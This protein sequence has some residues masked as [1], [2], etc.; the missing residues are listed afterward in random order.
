MAK[1]VPAFADD[2]GAIHLTAEKAVLA[3]L[4]AILGRIGAEAGLTNGLAQTILD[5][6]SDIERIFAQAD[7]IAEALADARR[8]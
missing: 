1:I 2:S 3:D 6:R 5:K 8:S 4:S 7:D